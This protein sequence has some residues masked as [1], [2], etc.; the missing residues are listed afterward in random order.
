MHNRW[1]P[2]TFATAV[3]ASS[4]KT[5]KRNQSEASQRKRY[6]CTVAVTSLPN[7]I[8]IHSGCRR[9][10]KVLASRR[11]QETLTSRLWAAGLGKS[12]R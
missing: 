3:F 11:R 7:Q 8:S 9:A 2:A 6:D 12:S 1:A 10:R 5:G 4:A